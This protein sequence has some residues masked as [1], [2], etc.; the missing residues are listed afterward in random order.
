MEG[1]QTHLVGWN[2][3][4]RFKKNPQG[5]YYYWEYLLNLYF[6]YW[7]RAFFWKHYS[8]LL[9]QLVALNCKL[10]WK[11]KFRWS[12]SGKLFRVVSI[13][14]TNSALHDKIKFIMKMITNYLTILQNLREK[15][16]LLFVMHVFF[17]GGAVLT[18]LLVVLTGFVRLFW[19]YDSLL[20]LDFNLLIISRF[21]K[22]F[23]SY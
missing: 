1:S 12:L 17:V 6:F 23:F 11:I 18:L 22:F 21:M 10:T 19:N 8:S 15:H 13:S 3:F 4:K 14:E 2:L 9:K 16:T 5:Q 20:C 7:T